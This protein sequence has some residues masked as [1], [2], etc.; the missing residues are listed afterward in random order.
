MAGSEDGSPANEGYRDA[1][2]MR[3]LQVVADGDPGGGTTHVLQILKGLSETYSLGLVTQ[4]DS[5]LLN[6]GQR[7]GIPTYGVDFFRSRL[8]LR[9]PFQLHRIV[10]EFGAQ[11]VHAHG[12]RAAFFYSLAPSKVPFV[13]SV[14]GYHFL[15]KSPPVRRLALSA[16]RAAARR[17]QRVVFESEHDSRI[18]RV[19]GM[20]RGSAQSTIVPNSIPLSEIRVP[21]LNQ[22]RHIGL[23]GRLE[24][25]KDPILFLEVLEQLPGYT[26]TIAG[27]G[28]LEK[29]VGD[30]LRRRGL[31][32][33][34]EML[35]TLTHAETLRVVSSLRTVVMTSRWEGLPN[36]PLE[37]MWTGVP[38]VATNVG[39]LDEIIENEKNGLLVDGRSPDDIARAVRRVTEDAALRERIVKNARDRVRSMFS[40]ERMLADL[41]EIYRQ[42]AGA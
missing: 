27:G 29:E 22:P 7:I 42:A 13:Y 35:G 8:D 16:E 39:A 4:K 19:Y 38:V 5:Y 6:E 1:G 17:A 12:G 20:L 3:I 37:A 11:M 26:A 9:V 40:E 24:Y 36:L 14:H 34:V 32:G 31:T 2:K 10:R 28:A 21:R 23:V 18:A 33:T 25:Q 30:E 15:H 41:R